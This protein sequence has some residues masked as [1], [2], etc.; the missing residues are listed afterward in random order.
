MFDILDKRI[1]VFILKINN[2]L[3]DII[4]QF[5][6]I[7]SRFFAMTMTLKSLEKNQSLCH[8]E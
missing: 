3:S 1:L 4:F 2:H 7:L 5:I 6:I 8:P